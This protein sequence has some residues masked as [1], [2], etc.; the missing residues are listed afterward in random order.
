VTASIVRWLLGA[1]AEPVPFVTYYPAIVVCTL[2]AGWRA[3]LASIFLS[4]ALVNLVFIQPKMVITADWRTIT[5]MGLFVLSCGMLVA[6]A[7]TLRAT[8]TS[9]QAATDRTE[10][11]NQELLH[12]VRNSLTL[13][14]SLA[15]MTHRSDPANFVAAFSKRMTA[16]AEGLDVLSRQ[17][18]QECDLHE[19]V[20]QALA[21]FV[22][23]D[24][25][26]VSGP[27]CLLPPQACVPL[28]LAIHE[29]CTNAVKYGALSSRAGCIRIEIQ[30]DKQ[31]G[32]ARLT[33]QELGGPVVSPPQ[34]SGLGTALL[35][36]P[37]LGPASLT[38]HP[39]GL[40]CEMRL[41]SSC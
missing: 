30:L 25:I 11:L 12:R 2:L 35:A 41:R 3:G 20:A 1:A 13:V 23:D 39:Q 6:I 37:V 38:Y 31:H 32:E 26:A 8:V 22:Q 34:R 9:L 27:T 4:M 28:V 21:P 33:W 16:L 10:Y 18:G 14:N 17:D 15:A 29:L 24:R 19:T 7:Q 5:M 40:Q 36:D